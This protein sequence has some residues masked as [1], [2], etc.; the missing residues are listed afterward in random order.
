MKAKLHGKAK[1]QVQNFNKVC[2]H[3]RHD[4]DQITLLL[5]QFNQL[6]STLNSITNI[7][8]SNKMDDLR[9]IFPGIMD[10]LTGSVITEIEDTSNQIKSFMRS[11]GDVEAAMKQAALES[12]SLC[13]D[14]GR[15]LV[16]ASEDN[17]GGGLDMLLH[18]QRA[19][20]KY[21]SDYYAKSILI[22]KLFG[23][24]SDGAS[25][26]SYW[27]KCDVIKEVLEQWN[28]DIT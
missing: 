12:R 14:K 18:I 20:A 19:Q 9:I 4:C 23:E 25:K 15:D 7:A 13:A 16:Q 26:D 2:T 17:D 21:S 6:A 5:Q 28:N 3:W 27:V 22:D 8:S 1:Y 24:N 11:L 10:R